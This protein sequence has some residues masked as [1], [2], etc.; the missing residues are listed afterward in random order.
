MR[1]HHHHHHH[2]HSH[3]GKSPTHVIS[4]QTAQL[5]SAAAA[6]AAAAAEEKSAAIA[7]AESS[8]L[9]PLANTGYTSSVQPGVAEYPPHAHHIPLTPIPPILPGATVESDHSGSS[10]SAL[11]DEE[12]GRGKGDV[13]AG[14]GFAFGDGGG[15]DGDDDDDNGEG[16]GY[17]ED[18]GSRAERARVRAEK[19]KAKAKAAEA[20]AKREKQIARALGM[21]EPKWAFAQRKIRTVVDSTALMVVLLLATLYVLYAEDILLLTLPPQADIV[22]LAIVGLCFLLF[23][24]ELVLSLAAYPVEYLSFYFWFDLLTLIS[25]V[26][27]LVLLFSA[28]DTT[29]DPDGVAARF[30]VLTIA[31][32]GRLARL[33]SRAGRLLRIIRI[34]VRCHA[35]SDAEFGGSPNL[36]TNFVG[37]GNNNR[38]H[39][40]HNHHHHHVVN[41]VTRD[42]HESSIVGRRYTTLLT[43]IFVLM[44]LIT[45]FAFVILET[46]R[47]P[48]QNQAH[49]SEQYGLDVLESGNTPLGNGSLSDP[50]VA[51][52]LR[53]HPDVLS[54]ILLNT[55]AIPSTTADSLRVLERTRVYSSSSRSMVFVDNRDEVKRDA[56]LNI[57]QTTVILFVLFAGSLLLVRNAQNMLIH[58]LE[59]MSLIAVD[60]LAGTGPMAA[61]PPGSAGDSTNKVSKSSSSSS[62]RASSVGVVLPSSAPSSSDDTSRTLQRSHAQRQIQG[63]ASIF[64]SKEDETSTLVD[65]LSS[66][67]SISLSGFG[68]LGWSILNRMLLPS[69]ELDFMSAGKVSHGVFVACDLSPYLA[70]VIVLKGN[71]APLVNAAISVVHA[72][73]E[74]TNGEL[75]KLRDN[76][77]FAAWLQSRPFSK[78]P[79][80]GRVSAFD[81]ALNSMLH[82]LSDFVSSAP[83][84][85]L[86]ALAGL[87]PP[88]SSKSSSSVLSG[89]MTPTGLLASVSLHAGWAVEAAL[90]TDA[91]VEPLLIGPHIDLSSYL[92][93]LASFYGVPILFSASVYSRLSPLFQRR[94]RR[95]DRILV[96]ATN[97]AIDVYTLDNLTPLSSEEL[98]LVRTRSSMVGAGA[99]SLSHFAHRDPEASLVYDTALTAYID[100][101]WR[102]ARPLF[103]EYLETHPDD[104]PANNLVRFVED[105]CDEDGGAPLQW[106]GARVVVL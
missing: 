48:S 68:R 24:T 72:R 47:A 31:R 54:L 58:P 44:V 69:R 63:D 30:S 76:A 16:E 78:G 65:V 36:V 94:A 104:G 43:R 29:R 21:V 59:D 49:R 10:S 28:S 86:R 6:A 71:V 81:E 92:R 77:V 51:L 106:R 87:P 96:P 22:H 11:G 19:A 27:D 97:K 25:M 53:A 101:R 38:D 100:G 2:H 12:S 89:L 84:A 15:E 41:S 98:E 62:R 5:A 13:E 55:V 42:A 35:A 74:E 103:L 75:T 82:V 45:V 40:H 17:E 14:E 7:Q 32:A 50:G 67:R 56:V 83:L 20:E 73:L 70:P 57:I 1:R 23:A 91:L 85:H 34:M 80:S 52:Y 61:G 18:Y 33:G 60:L 8:V 105:T 9:D 90:G 37:S 102:E 39:H 4:P 79:E 46:F 88:P 99:S 26:P 93:R 3:H 66:V 64:G 95:L